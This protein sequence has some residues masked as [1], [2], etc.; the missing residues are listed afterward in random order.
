MLAHDLR[1]G[2]FV[3]RCFF[4]DFSNVERN[5]PQ[6]VEHLPRQFF[7]IG[8]V[9]DHAPLMEG[10]KLPRVAPQQSCPLAQECLFL[11]RQQILC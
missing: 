7:I 6:S 10:Y 9:S 5:I 11:H 8:S 1:R 4:L 2:Q 3:N